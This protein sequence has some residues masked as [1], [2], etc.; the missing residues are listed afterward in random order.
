[1]SN[2]EIFIIVSAERHGTDTLCKK[3]EEL[4]DSFCFFEAF[5]RDD[6]ISGRHGLFPKFMNKK[7]N[8]SKDYSLFLKNVFNIILPKHKKISFKLFPGHIS[9]INF[10]ETDDPRVFKDFHFLLNL[11]IKTTFILLK[12]DLEDAFASYFR[13]CTTGD[14]TNNRSLGESSWRS[15]WVKEE[16]E[17]I[18]KKDY[19]NKL[20][21]WFTAWENILKQKSL[22]FKQLN[23]CD[24]I[25][26]DFCLSNFLDQ[27]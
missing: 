13:A 19:A 17:V 27:K 22:N 2:R 7:R 14:W 10:Y 25:Q 8:I 20:N 15:E 4:E 1:M 12:R 5:N 11:D 16:C 9:G 23:F 21:Q 18:S 6:Q 24:L 3:F 26:K